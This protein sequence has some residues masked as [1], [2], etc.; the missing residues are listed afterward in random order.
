MLAWG[1]WAALAAVHL[2][3]Q[4]GRHNVTAVIFVADIS[5]YDQNL[6]EDGSTNRMVS[7]TDALN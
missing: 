7:S 2:G 4:I 6:Y 5:E 3:G 1:K